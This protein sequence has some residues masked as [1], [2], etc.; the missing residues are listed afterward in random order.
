MDNFT[1]YKKNRDVILKRV[2]DYII[3]MLKPLERI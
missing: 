2:K 3:T 1:Y